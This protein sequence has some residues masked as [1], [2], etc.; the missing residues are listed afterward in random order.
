MLAIVFKSHH[1]SKIVNRSIEH[2]TFLNIHNRAVGLGMFVLQASK[3]VDEI[4]SW[5]IRKFKPQKGLSLW[6]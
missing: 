1:I 2:V 5:S 4:K 3:V 6:V